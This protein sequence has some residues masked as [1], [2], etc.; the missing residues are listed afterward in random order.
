MKEVDINV[1]DD[2]QI[3]D[4]KDLD[5]KLDNTVKIQSGDMDEVWLGIHLDGLGSVSIP[6]GY[7][8]DELQNINFSYT[9]DDQKHI[10]DVSTNVSNKVVQKHY[11]KSEFEKNKKDF[12]KLGILKGNICMEAAKEYKNWL[13]KFDE[14]DP[15]RTEKAKYL[16]ANTQKGSYY[17]SFGISGF[18]QK[19][20]QAAVDNY[21]SSVFLQN[22]DNIKKLTVGEFFDYVGITDQKTI[23]GTMSNY[24]LNYPGL[25]KDTNAYDL[26][27]SRAKLHSGKKNVEITDKMVLKDLKD[28]YVHLAVMGWIS[29]GTAIYKSQLKDEDKELFDLGNSIVSFGSASKNKEFK[30]WVKDEAPALMHKEELD[31]M[32]ASHK[33][34]YDICLA[35]KP[36]EIEKKGI[37]GK[38]LSPSKPSK[39][40]L[41]NYIK[42]H[43]GYE[44]I[45][46]SDPATRKVHAAKLMAATKLKS[47]NKAYDIKLIHK[48]ADSLMN[49]EEFNQISS[50]DILESLS[51]PNKAKEVNDRIHD[52]KYGVEENRRQEYINEMKTLSDNMMKK[53]GCSAE[54]KALWD[55]VKTVSEMSPEDNFSN[56]NDKLIGAI[57]NY[58][59]GKKSVRVRDNGKARFENAVDA[60][61]I[62]NKYVPGSHTIVEGQVNRINGV[63][64]VKAG[65]RYFIDIE[66]HGANNAKAK[67]EAR[68][69]NNQKS[70]NVQ[71]EQKEKKVIKSL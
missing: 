48:Y 63:R 8:P 62:I 7:T 18:Q 52:V 14:N 37:V 42:K 11:G 69:K 43:S 54:Y 28:E 21:K 20:E 6:K 16:T 22:I 30:K 59:K 38:L 58:T 53:E 2:N 1:F 65:D 31:N 24:K 44:I 13:D 19:A 33:K 3:F 57:L 4:N 45:A 70:Q 39:S 36:Y 49:T 9:E 56:A 5:K 12:V 46:D 68:A 17:S 61:A 71:K 25:T 41:D 10:F 51:T 55:A 27:K 29:T 50:L 67:N 66:Q 40:K 15:L 26:F 23:D 60:L 34:M 47:M 35:D 64:K 32:N